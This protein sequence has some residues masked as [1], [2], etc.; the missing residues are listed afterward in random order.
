M[1]FQFFLVVI[2]FLIPCRSKA[3]L[4]PNF[5]VQAGLNYSNSKLTS[6][7]GGFSDNNMYRVGHSFG[8]FSNFYFSNR[9]A[10]TPSITFSSKGYQYEN[11]V[12]FDNNGEVSF[13]PGIWVNGSSVFSNNETTAI[14]LNY[15]SLQ[16]LLNLKVTK[17]LGLLIG[18]EF[19]FRISSKAKY[20][21][22]T[23]E[24]N[25]IW[26]NDFDTGLTVAV[27]W[28]FTE[29]LGS[30]LAYTHN[31]TSVITSLE[32]SINAELQNRTFQ[33]MLTYLIISVDANNR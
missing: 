23:F 24:V 5:G 3:Q 1:K 21:N 32:Q 20:K 10:I 18:P 19:S 12:S 6:N 30:V 17:Q 26:D 15:I 11:G 27:K 29:N 31:F 22:E 9:F 16:L 25:D 7:K 33:V 4:Q 14:Q 28:Q 13:N 2:I 8:V